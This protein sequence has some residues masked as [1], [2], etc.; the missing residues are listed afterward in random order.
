MSSRRDHVGGSGL[1]RRRRVR[2]RETTD[3]LVRIRI[4]EVIRE[5]RAHGRRRMAGRLPYTGIGPVDYTI[6]GSELPV[7][8]RLAY[9]LPLGGG[10]WEPQE[11]RLQLLPTEPTYG[12]VR[13][14]FLCPQCG[15]RCGVLYLQRT[16]PLPWACRLCSGLVYRSQLE[17]Q[18]GRRVRKLRKVLA[19]AG[20]AVTAISGAGLRTPRPRGMH[21]RTFRRLR[22]EADRLF[23]EIVAIRGGHRRL[24]RMWD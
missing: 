17:G 15:R 11:H 1:S 3:D 4:S 13:W 9:R 19:R 21:R 14:W 5:A 12:G 8:L 18:T 23:L 7:I 6:D 10:G 2:W 16:A 22:Q 20:G 24:E